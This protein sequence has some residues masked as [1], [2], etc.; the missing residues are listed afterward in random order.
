MKEEKYEES[1]KHLRDFMK[2]LTECL[3]FI[4]YVKP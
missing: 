1:N 3:E 4:G 2:D